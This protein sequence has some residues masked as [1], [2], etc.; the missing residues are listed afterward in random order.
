MRLCSPYTPRAGPGCSNQRQLFAQRAMHCCGTGPSRDPHERDRLLG[1]DS[2]PKNS[3]IVVMFCQ[4][5]QIIRRQSPGWRN[6]VTLF[7]V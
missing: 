2:P 7:C 6:L 5:P 1:L 3:I 4:K